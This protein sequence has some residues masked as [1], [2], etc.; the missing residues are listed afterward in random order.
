MLKC[1][2]DENLDLTKIEISPQLVDN[3]LHICTPLCHLDNENITL[4][5]KNYTTK[6]QPEKAI[7]QLLYNIENYTAP[8]KVLNIDLDLYQM[9]NY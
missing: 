3:T 1:P 8:E 7:N 6:T 9:E 4:Q 2:L 5:P